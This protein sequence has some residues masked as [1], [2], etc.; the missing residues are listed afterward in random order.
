M[1]N[2]ENECL[3]KCERSYTYAMDLLEKENDIFTRMVESLGE[4]KY[5]NL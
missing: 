5:E 3:D 4:K 2:Q 1:T